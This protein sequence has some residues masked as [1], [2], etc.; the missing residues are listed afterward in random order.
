MGIHS[1]SWTSFQTMKLGFIFSPT[2]NG[3]LCL[4]MNLQNYLLYV[5]W[6]ARKAMCVLAISHSCIPSHF[7]QFHNALSISE[8][9]L[10]DTNI[11]IIF[12]DIFKF[13]SR[14]SHFSTWH[15][16]EHATFTKTR[17]WADDQRDGRPAIDGAVC[18]SSVIPFRVPCHNVWLT[19]AAG[20]PCSTASSIGECK[21][22][23]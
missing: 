1:C 12:S 15:D 10:F 6:Q 7:Q 14:S 20:V 5:Q 22:W 3:S 17:M 9:C 8:T 19:P 16:E 18:E 23:M 13:L 4:P 21:T 2:R 11:W